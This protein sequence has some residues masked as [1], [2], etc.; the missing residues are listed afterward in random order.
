[1]NYI[2]IFLTILITLYGQ[3]ILKLHIVYLGWSIPK[4]SF[5]LMDISYIKLMF[6]LFIFSGLATAFLASIC[7]IIV[8]TNFEKTFTSPLISLFL[9]IV[10]IFGIL[11]LNETLTLGKVL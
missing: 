1:M 5:S 6:D 3:I 10:L 4:S 8:I 11:F 9:T 7:R 2:Y